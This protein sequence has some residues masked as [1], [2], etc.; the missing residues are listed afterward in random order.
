MLEPSHDPEKFLKW[1]IG[2]MILLFLIWLVTGGPERLKEEGA[3]PFIEELVPL[4][5]SGI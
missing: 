5:T 3:E 4:D 2:F 1:L